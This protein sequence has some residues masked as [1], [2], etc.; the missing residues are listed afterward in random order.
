M[1]MP[2]DESLGSVYVL[3]CLDLEKDLAK[4]KCVPL[5]LL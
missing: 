5:E 4:R 1:K 2:M 3:D